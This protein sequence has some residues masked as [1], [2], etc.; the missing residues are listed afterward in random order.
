MAT[1]TSNTTTTTTQPIND[2]KISTALIGSLRFGIQSISI[3]LFSLRELGIAG[4]AGAT[5]L[6]QMAEQS[7]SD[8]NKAY[9]QRQL[10]ELGI[11]S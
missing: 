5:A 3:N 2:G 8:K 10:K 1:K 9:L 6:K 7:L 11:N 4:A